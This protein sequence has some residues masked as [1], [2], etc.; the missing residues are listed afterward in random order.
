MDLGIL[1]VSTK[2]KTFNVFTCCDI[3][4]LAV[5]PVWREVVMYIFCSRH[6]YTGATDA[7]QILK[8][9]ACI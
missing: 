5:L 3:V 2:A 6:G 1:P 9:Q 4:G 8:S 7:A